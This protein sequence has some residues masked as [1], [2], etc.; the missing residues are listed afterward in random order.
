ML[1]SQAKLSG[2]SELGRD[3]SV[4]T[5]TPAELTPEE[6]A[7]WTAFVRAD[8]RYASPYF[9]PR[10]TLAAGEVAPG[11]AVAILHRNGEIAGFFPHQRR[12]SAAQPIGAPMNDYHGVIARPGGEV[13]LE[14]LPVLLGAASLNVNGWV[15]EGRG[16]NLVERQTLQ[17][18]LT[19]G[20]DAY[21]TGQR[22]EWRKFFRD[23][24]RARR[25]LER[26]RGE[27]T[28]RLGADLADLDRLIGLKSDQYR[29]SGR[30]D[31]FA[32]G[33]TADLLK[34]LLTSRDP[35]FGAT[36]AVLEAG[37]EPVAF[38]YGLHACDRYHFWLPAYEAQV[39]RYSPGMLLSL[40]TM[41]LS[42]DRGFKVFDLGFA[43]EPYKKYFAN[44]DET[45]LEGA[46]LQPG[47]ADAVSAA[48]S[49]VGGGAAL[50]AGQALAQAGLGL[51][52][53][54]RW[55]AIDACETT[56]GGR[57]RGVAAAASAA[58]GRIGAPR[59]EPGRLM[60]L[61]S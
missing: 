41:K 49:M 6:L 25:S 20:W 33:W 53:R 51:S 36:L 8:Q 55:A 45:V 5:V 16:D 27:V 17:A 15:G 40:D 58:I 56:I 60:H 23:K 43:G 19:N 61:N 12:G 46:A 48:L 32:C 29:R 7:L 57:M 52:V 14:A 22:T 26:D 39:A 59:T 44:R 21:D 31:I 3:L 38:E 37:G 4:E 1:P 10:F 28:V 11:A 50:E 24:D 35:D 13:A 30:H 42:A 2:G 9:H 18:D 54:R 34:V 47:F